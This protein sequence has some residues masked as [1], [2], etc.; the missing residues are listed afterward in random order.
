VAKLAGVK[1]HGEEFRK[2]TIEQCTAGLD[3]SGNEFHR[4]ARKKASV[5][6]T[7]VV[8][9]IKHPRAG[10]NAT[11]RTTY[12]NSSKPG[13]SPR[14][15]TGFGH[16]SIVGGRLGLAFRVGYT[17]LARYMAFHEL[18]IRYK[19]GGTQYR[20]TVIPAL[21]DNLTRIGMMFKRAATKVKR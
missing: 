14:M 7:P 13:E 1:W 9:P 8:V 3:A 10:G 12:P 21:R 2:F 16:A 20:P 4:I 11:S 15:R 6:N 17:R 19:R 18:G 5:Q